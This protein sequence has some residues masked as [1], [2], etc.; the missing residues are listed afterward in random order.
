VARAHTILFSQTEASSE[1][2]SSPTIFLTV[3]AS[4]DDTTSDFINKVQSTIRKICW[5]TVAH[6]SL[7]IRYEW[8]MQFQLRTNC[9][10]CF[11]YKRRNL[12]II[13][14]LPV[15]LIMRVDR[16]PIS[17]LH[18]SLFSDLLGMLFIVSPVHVVMSRWPSGSGRADAGRVVM[19]TCQALT[20]RGWKT[21]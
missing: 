2:R 7:S 11:V 18:S 3:P 21:E 16:T 9:W 19:Q 14:L 1:W 20:C 13:L 10:R 15:F 6:S 5:S 17:A 8:T 12:I 4:W